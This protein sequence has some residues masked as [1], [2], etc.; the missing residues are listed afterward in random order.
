MPDEDRLGPEAH[1]S[2]VGRGYLWSHLQCARSGAGGG[3]REFAAVPWKPAHRGLAARGLSS[4]VAQHFLSNLGPCLT[5]PIKVP[6]QLP[7]PPNR[8]GLAPALLS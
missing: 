6:W 2:L 5:F 8:P 1:W 7:H 3:G 4:Q